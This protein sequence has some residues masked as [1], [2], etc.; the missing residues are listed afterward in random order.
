MKKGLKIIAILII[1]LITLYFSYIAYTGYFIK[2][3]DA[4]KVALSSIENNTVIQTKTGGIVGYGTFPNGSITQNDAVILI[5]VEGKK[6]DAKIIAML[7]KLSG[8]KWRLYHM[9]NEFE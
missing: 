3:S 7:T 9:M 5:T 2:K 4:Y 1:C 8:N 6:S